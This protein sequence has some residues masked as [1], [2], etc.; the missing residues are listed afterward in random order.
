[1]IRRPSAGP[2]PRRMPG[3]VPM[4]VAQSLQDEDGRPH[5]GSRAFV[6]AVAGYA[7]CA[8]VPTYARLTQVATALPNGGDPLQHLWVMRWYK[9]CLLE[10]RSPLVCPEIQYPVGAPLGNFSP[11]HLQS[12]LYLLLSYFIKSDILC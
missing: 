12:L 10:G 2:G 3:R 7:L 1:M 5:L 8:V 6:V 11:L 4:P 9:T